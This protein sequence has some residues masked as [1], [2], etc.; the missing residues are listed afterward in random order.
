M[1]FE[2][3]LERLVR[4]LQEG[5]QSKSW[6]R[7]GGEI[8]EAA[9]AIILRPDASGDDTELL[10]IKRAQKK[11]DPWSGHMAFPGGRVDPED[12]DTLAAAKRETLEEIALPIDLH[13]EPIGSLSDI[14]AVAGGKVIPLVISAY[15]FMLTTEAPTL[16]LNHE[17][18][19]VVWVP[20]S[21]FLTPEKRE[22]MD[23]EREGVTWKLPCYMFEGK[24]IW[25][26]SLRM[27]D[28]MRERALRFSVVG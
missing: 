9:V 27:I 2:M 3:K 23:Y 10:M 16:T 28:E 8:K 7:A 22:E 5:G 12:E 6:E 21:L 4:S 14:P 11:G 25:G 18:E 13:A 15:L 20:F 17:V 24:R 1:A 19:E 26:L